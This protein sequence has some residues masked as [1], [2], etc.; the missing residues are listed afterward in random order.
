MPLS[1]HAAG[2]A[3][4]GAHRVVEQ[5]AGAD[6]GAFPRTPRQQQQEGERANQMGREAIEHAGPL[7]Q[8]LADETELQMFQV[9]QTAVDQLARAARGSRGQVARLDQRDPQTA[10][11]RVERSAAADHAAA[12]DRDVEH[13]VGHPRQCTAPLLEA[14]GAVV[15][16]HRRG[17]AQLR[18]PPRVP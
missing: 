12:D 4:G 15:S 13:L 16:E 18:S 14:E 17:G 3:E 1:G 9:A 6:V 5:E 10:R 8:G 11:G 7:V 2:A